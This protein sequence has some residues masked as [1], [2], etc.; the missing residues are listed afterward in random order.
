MVSRSEVFLAK[1]LPPLSCVMQNVVGNSNV[2][3]VIIV[4]CRF[5]RH[6]LISFIR[7]M[8]PVQ[9]DPREHERNLLWLDI[10]FNLESMSL[11]YH[12]KSFSTPPSWTSSPR[13]LRAYILSR[14]SRWRELDLDTPQLVSWTAVMLSSLVLNC[15]WT[16]RSLRYVLYTISGIDGRREIEILKHALRAIM[17]G[18]AWQHLE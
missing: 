16:K 5:C 3:D 17:S 4:S 11:N 13:T 10:S 15:G 9:F 2:D 6:C 8:Y 18:Q 14:V 12:C 7:Q 1:C